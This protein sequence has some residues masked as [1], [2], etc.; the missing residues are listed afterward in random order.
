MLGSD[1]LS[2]ALSD[3]LASHQFNYGDLAAV[4]LAKRYAALLDAGDADTAS[5]LGPKYLQVLASLG[6]TPVA[7]AALL[8][9]GDPGGQSASGDALARLRAARAN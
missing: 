8:K 4:A 6:M 5:D 7:R 3:A 9:G 2:Q 1:S